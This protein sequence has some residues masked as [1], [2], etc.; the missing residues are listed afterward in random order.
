MT[1]VDNYCSHYYCH[2]NVS[3]KKRTNFETVL[4]EIIRIDYDDIWQKYSR[5]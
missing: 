2:Y 1:A 3:W 4:L 5:L